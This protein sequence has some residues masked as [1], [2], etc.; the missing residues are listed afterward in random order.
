LPEIAAHDPLKS[1]LTIPRN[2][3]SRCSEIPA[4]DPAKRAFVHVR[5][6][7]SCI[8]MPNQ[9]KESAVAFLEAA[10]AYYDKL[11]I[12]IELV[13]T[14]NGSC[15]Q[16]KTFRAACKRLDL[17]QIFTR[18]YTRDQRQSQRFIQTALREWAL[19][20]L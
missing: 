13:M 4:H 10:V 17:R 5:A 19:S 1:L 15:C 8:V 6:L 20:E 7:P 18:P 12:R 11:G 3:C 14:D 9:R 16:S 2:I